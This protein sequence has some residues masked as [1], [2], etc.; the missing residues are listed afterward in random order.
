MKLLIKATLFFLLIPLVCVSCLKKKELPYTDDFKKLMGF[1]FNAAKFVQ[2]IEDQKNFTYYQSIYEANKK[3]LWEVSNKQRIP[4]I[5]HFIWL[6]PESFPM[7]SI[8][9]I[10]SW[11]LHHPD[12]KIKF[13]TDQKKEAPHPNME[14][15]VVDKSHF[16]NLY[17]EYLDSKN[18]AEKSDVLRYEILFHE[19]GIY[20][21]HDVKCF[22]SFDQFSRNFDFFSGIE[23]L[24]EPLLSSSVLVCNNL[25]GACPN[26]PIV[27]ICHQL[28]KDRWD[29][30]GKAFPGDDKESLV[31]RVGYRSFSSFDDAVKLGMHQGTYN[32]IVLPAGYLNRI[33]D[34]F[35][36]YAHHYYASTWF[37]NETKENLQIRKKLREIIK[38]TN[39]QMTF[40]SAL[41]LLNIILVLCFIKRFRELSKT[42]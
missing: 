6:G 13:W 21:D 36:Y 26:H 42:A 24:H 1:D 27:K 17:E 38:R 18:Y 29:R 35:G 14:V 22:Q 16:T 34:N 8:D 2:T 12:W 11:I 4:K 33:H 19:G 37:E 32:N 3:Y 31:Y 10:N 9:N 28:V 39:Q 15:V 20:V 25:I 7:K 5:I 23:P 41:L 40:S 30:M